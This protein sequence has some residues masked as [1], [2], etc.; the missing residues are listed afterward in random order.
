MEGQHQDKAAT[1]TADGVKGNITIPADE[2]SQENQQDVAIMKESSTK[3]DAT[4]QEEKL[5]L[6]TEPNI[7]NHDA[8]FQEN[9]QELQ[10]QSEPEISL[11][12]IHD[13]VPYDVRNLRKPLSIYEIQAQPNEMVSQT[14]QTSNRYLFSMFVLSHT[15]YHKRKG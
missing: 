8:E 2:V 6:T 1:S 7:I 14:F 10:K 13:A 12:D 11:E 15:S 3:V 9:F 5:K 4:T